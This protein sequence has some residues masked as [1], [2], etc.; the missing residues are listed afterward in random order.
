VPPI[1]APE[2]RAAET[3]EDTTETETVLDAVPQ[4]SVVLEQELDE[5]GDVAELGVD[6][7]DT[8]ES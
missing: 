3:S 8:K 6:G 2:E 5:G 1:H 4:D 7:L